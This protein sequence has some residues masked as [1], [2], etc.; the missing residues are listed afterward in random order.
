MWAPDSRWAGEVVEEVA[1]FPAGDHDDY[2]D[3]C[4]QAL[5]RVRQGGF[6]RLPSDE[7]EEPKYWRSSR[8]AS[9]Y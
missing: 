8:K 4:T 6:I 9:Y 3:T 7:P 1:A 5:M 2:V